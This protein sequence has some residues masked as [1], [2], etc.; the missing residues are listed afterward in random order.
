LRSKSGKHFPIDDSAA[1]IKDER[2][3][4]IGAVL[5]FRDI[6]ERRNAERA[7]KESEEK[8]RKLINHANDAIIMANTRLCISDANKKAEDLTGYSRDELIGMDFFDLFVSVEHTR[9]NKSLKQGMSKKSYSLNDVLLR[10]KN[11]S[12]CP[13]DVNGSLIEYADKKIFQAILRDNSVRKIEELEREKLI[14]EL[15][16][17]LEKVKKLNGMLPICASCKK[18][19]DDKGYW[20]QIEAYMQEHSDL[21]FSHSLCPDC[22]AELYPEMYTK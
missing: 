1:P 20:N 13:V 4:I 19:R 11:T 8:Y 16:T 21:E 18:I 5:V 12:V 17:A 2:G 10:Q 3:N 14:T 15:K 9:M 22:L 6:A 7:L